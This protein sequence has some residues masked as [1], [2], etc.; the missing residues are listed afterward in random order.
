MTENLGENLVHLRGGRLSANAG[1]ELG[2]DHM[3]GRLHIRPLIVVREEF[4]AIVR[5]K[6][7]HLAPQL[8][9][10]L[11]DAAVRP[12]APVA[13][14]GIVVRLEGYQRKRASTGDSVEVGVADVALVSGDGLDLETLSG[15][16]KER[17]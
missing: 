17:G 16:L 6:L 2:L 5:E 3:E 8:P 15:R 12:F 4:L 7:V 13:A 11:G 1:A 10:T 14:T 9:A